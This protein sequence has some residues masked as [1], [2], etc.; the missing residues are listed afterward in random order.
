[1][2]PHRLSSRQWVLVTSVAVAL[3]LAL[4]GLE[5]PGRLVAERVWVALARELLS[6]GFDP[7]R[8]DLIFYPPLFPHVVGLALLC[9]GSL[10]AAK[11]LQILAGTLL[12]A[13]IASVGA[14]VFG[15]RTGLAAGLCAAGYPDLVWYSVH[16]WSEPVFMALLWWGFDRL[17]AADE[18]LSG[19]SAVAAGAL[20]GLATLTR[21]AILYFLPVAALWVAW[22]R[23]GGAPRAA[24]LLVVALP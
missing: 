15:N 24:L 1:M 9:G 17:L 23:P 18:R 20:L 4:L 6:V 13:A 10:V 2:D 3:R 5:P 11:L 19:R 8:S 12:V 22:R 7:L 21:E 16:L 14:R